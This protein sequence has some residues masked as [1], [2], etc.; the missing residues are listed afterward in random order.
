MGGYPPAEDRVVTQAGPGISEVSRSQLQRS[1]ILAALI[2]AGTDGLLEGK[3]KELGG[4]WWPKRVAELAKGH[5][6]GWDEVDGEK[7]YFLAGHDEREA[8]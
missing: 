2:E 4:Y 8:A 1:A 3:I 7:R 5:A 6:I